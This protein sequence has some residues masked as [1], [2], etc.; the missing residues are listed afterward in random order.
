MPAPGS[1]AHVAKSA[2][3]HEV[4]GHHGLPD[5]GIVVLVVEVCA[6]QLHAQ[7]CAYPDLQHDALIS[8]MET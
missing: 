2:H 8:P 5:V 1:A 6:D 7:P 3:L 4:P